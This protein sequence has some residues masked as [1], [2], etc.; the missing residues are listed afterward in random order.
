VDCGV[1]FTAINLIYAFATGGIPYGSVSGALG[2]PVNLQARGGPALT[3]RAFVGRPVYGA[4]LRKSAFN[5]F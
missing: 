4:G 3:Q 5:F 2:N 1:I